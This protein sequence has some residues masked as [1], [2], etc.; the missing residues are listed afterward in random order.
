MEKRDWSNITLKDYYEIQ[1][2]ISVQDDY[3]TFNLLDFL[4][5]IDSSNM[6]LREISEYKNSLSFLDSIDVAYKNIQLEDKYVIN[7]TTYVGFV[8]LT[9]V[10]VAQFIDYQNYLK[11]TPVKFEK[12]LS[13]FIVPEG[14]T[15]NDGYD[16]KQ[17]QRDLL[18]L[19]FVVVQKIS[20]FF[21]KQLQVF[22][23][24]TL[25]CLT[26]EL[27]NLK[28]KKGKRLLLNESL[29]KMN[30]LLSESSHIV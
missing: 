10:N 17:V 13:V 8:D 9:Q 20:F 14:H 2:I 25:F 29:E 19:P 15:Y 1:N 27:K 6:T 30:L 24:T 22:V 4:Y 5:N 23:Q 26:G 21:L 3:T 12:V 11:E 28:L 18:E 7:G 16:I